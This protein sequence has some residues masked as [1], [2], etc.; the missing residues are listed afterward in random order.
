VW[1]TTICFVVDNELGTATAIATV[2]SLN[3]FV[4]LVVSYSS[5]FVLQDNNH[6]GT[7]CKTV[8]VAVAI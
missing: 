6:N 3:L 5:I 1:D 2:S 7:I 4:L 8:D